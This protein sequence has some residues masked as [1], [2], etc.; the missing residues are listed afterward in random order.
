MMNENFCATG[1]GVATQA[2]P[3]SNTSDNLRDATSAMGGGGQGAVRSGVQQVKEQVKEKARDAAHQAKDTARHAMDQ[4]KEQA[5]NA[6]DQLRRKGESLAAQ[7]KDRVAKELA[8]VGAAVRQASTTLEGDHEQHLA[9]YTRFVAERCEQGALYLRRHETG[10]LVSEV[11]R[12][13]RRHP[14]V[15]FGG[16]FLGGLVLGRFLKASRPQPRYDEMLD[17]EHEYE[18]D[19]PED[20]LHLARSGDAFGQEQGYSQ[21]THFEGSATFADRERAANRNTLQEDWRGERSQ[22]VSWTASDATSGGSTSMSSA[23]AA[24][25]GASGMGGTA[26]SLTSRDAL[27]SDA[28][29]R[30]AAGHSMTAG[31]A[32]PTPTPAQGPVPTLPPSMSDPDQVDQPADVGYSPN[33]PR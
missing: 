26:S 3:T 5:M 16:L 30:E 6:A 13:A 29:R 22:S 1:G 17:F 14:E 2:S 4:A 28:P 21:E 11:E 32:C 8:R 15:I 12:F 18:G 31:G 25:Q 33:K 20:E 24:G 9:G 23:G 10:E 7:Q 27:S 19:F